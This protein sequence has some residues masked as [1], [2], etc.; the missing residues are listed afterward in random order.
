MT[1]S[2]HLHWTRTGVGRRSLQCLAA[3]ALF[4]CCALRCGAVE[5]G[6]FRYQWEHPRL[7]EVQLADD[8]DRHDELCFEKELLL[9]RCEK[10]FDV[11][12]PALFLEDSLTGEGIAFFRQA[13]LPHARTCGLPDWH[14]DPLAR[15]VDVLSNGYRCASIRYCGGKAGRVRAATDFHRASRPYVAGRDGLFLSNTWGDGNRDACINE[16][17]LLQEVASGAE[18]GVDVIQIDDGW[19][20]G[21][22]ANSASLAAGEKGRWGS[23]W[24]VDGF[25]DV[26]P[27]RFP[28]GLAN[29]VEEA[30]SKGMKFGLWF[31]PDSSDDAANWKRDADFLLSL[32]RNLGVDYFKFDSMH[33]PSPLA[34]S[35]QG[36]LMDRLMDESKDRI[37]ID[38]DVT[39]G[40]RPGYF[41]F[42]RIGPVFVENR[43]IREKDVRLWWPHRTLRNLWGLAHVVDPARLRME[44]LN[45]ERKPELYPEGDPL[46][47]MRWPRDAVF[48]VSMV[49]SP[50]GWF[51]IQNLSPETVAAW[52]P[53]I[54]RWKKE[55]DAMHAGYIYPV[56]SAPD[57]LSWTGFVTASRDGA[58]GTA[59][60][61]RE[62]D[63]REE[64]SLPISEYFP[65]GCEAAGVIGGRGTAKV[66]DGVLKV[67]VREKLDFVWV[68]I[69]KASGASWSRASAEKLVATWCDALVARQVAGTGD[70]MIDGGIACPAC[71]VMHGRVCDLVYPL[72]YRWS[73]TGDEKYLKAAE[74]AVEWSEA[75]MRRED[76]GVYNDY[77][78]LW[79]GTTVFAQIALGK[80]LLHYGDRLP[81]DVRGRWRDIFRRNTDFVVERFDDKFVNSTNVNYPAAF[82]EAMALAGVVLEDDDKTARAKAMAEWLMA[83]FLP[84]GLV[85]GEGA[86]MSRRSPR[87]HAYV[88][89]GYNLEETL[90]S[91]LAYAEICGDARM[92]EAVLSSAAAHAEFLLPD[93]G[94]DDSFGSRNPKWTYYGSRTSDGILPILGG[95]A[96]AGVPWAV[97]AMGLHLGLYRRCTNSSGLLAGG[98]QYEEAGEPACVHHAFAHVKSVVDVLRD[99]SIP[100]RG[101]DSPLPREKASGLKSF[102]SIGVELAAVGPWRVTFAGGDSFVQGM[103]G[104]RVSGGGPSLAWHVAVGP[105]IVGTMADYSIIEARN[106]QDLRHERTVLSMT[107]RIEADD[108]SSS[109]RDVEADMSAASSS[110]AVVCSARGRLTG[111]RGARGAAYEL[112]SRVDGKSLSI[113][114]KCGKDARFILPVVA[115]ET[116]RVEV[117]NGRV[118]I[119]RGGSVVTVESELPFELA[120]TDRGERAFSPVA[121]FLYAYLTAPIRADRAFCVR[122]SVEPK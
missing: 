108:G 12:A 66:E 107:P 105:V 18:L 73:I 119:E 69:G 38:L 26:D 19:Q 118:R 87:G 102:P 68:K 6:E 122:I 40:T 115:L 43:Y 52:K 25:W 4:A 120:K 106:L 89:I 88:D 93:G 5:S 33:T 23:W 32:H 95:L 56:G 24:E 101:A 48:A 104:H 2:R 8:T 72:V 112:V 78:S 97:K 116:D 80:T 46:A 91:L 50:L 54:A 16:R 27:V 110:N 28:R 82:C 113:E 84:D 65:A 109:A 117:G 15:R 79:W 35:R 58:E 59:L 74:R 14:V 13:P 62:L 34:L 39:A 60:L 64:F 31:G 51:E 57:G 21:R 30:R 1:E 49:S 77:Q 17:F 81:R 85:T 63:A 44:V 47:P 121:G 29:I 53:L 37:T 55:R 98:M 11:T 114:G 75:T 71:G 83:A 36:M 70:R 76:G 3:A 9:S 20:K 41:A 22:S 45:P 111:P 61:F 99:S 90:P 96:K 86:P 103:A 100:D 67:A 92:K 94:M 10:P 42:P 7:V